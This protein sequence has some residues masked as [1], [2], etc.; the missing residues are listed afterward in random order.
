MLIIISNFI[1]DTPELMPVLIDLL[2]K[3][4]LTDC[5]IRTL[6][7]VTLRSDFGSLGDVIPL[8]AHY[9]NLLDRVHGP[10]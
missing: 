1:E 8:V 2:Y 9:I 3:T 5:A 10:S 7:I 4:P 6:Y